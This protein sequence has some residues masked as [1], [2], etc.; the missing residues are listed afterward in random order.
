MTKD[1]A[2]EILENACKGLARNE[3]FFKTPT[4]IM[5]DTLDAYSK[6]QKPATHTAQSEAGVNNCYHTFHGIG[7]EY[8]E[9]TKCGMRKHISNLMP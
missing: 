8:F 9:C 5:G 1:E 2:I 4:Q 3:D 7:S 6:S